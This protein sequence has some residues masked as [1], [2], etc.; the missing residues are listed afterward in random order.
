MTCT[1]AVGKALELYFF[2]CEHFGQKD[3][4]WA[5]KVYL[6]KYFVSHECHDKYFFWSLFSGAECKYQSQELKIE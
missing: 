4:N 1:G 5:I 6:P 3:L 2:S